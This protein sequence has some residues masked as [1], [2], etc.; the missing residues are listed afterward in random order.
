MSLPLWLAIAWSEALYT[1]RHSSDFLQLAP[2]LKKVVALQ[3]R[4]I[5]IPDH[6]FLSFR[7]INGS[8][9]RVRALKR[10]N[11]KYTD[12][13]YVSAVKRGQTFKINIAT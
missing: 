4:V 3:L 6:F 7:P 8:P 5:R 1:T 2:H 12:L 11:A 9:K 13:A 10:S